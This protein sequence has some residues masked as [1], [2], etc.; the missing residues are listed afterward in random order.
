MGENRFDEAI[1]YCHQALMYVKDD[2]TRSEIWGDIGDIE[3]HRNEKKRCYKAYD[4]ALQYNPDNHSVLNNYAYFLS[5]EGRNLEQALAMASRA[6]SVTRILAPVLRSSAIPLSASG[7]ILKLSIMISVRE[8][9][10]FLA[11]VLTSRPAR[12]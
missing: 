1:E 12:V 11:R 2:I 5:E 10:R 9:I 7:L 6:I 8:S 3:A 4:K